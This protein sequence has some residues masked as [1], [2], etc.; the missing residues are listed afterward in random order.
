[1]VAQGVGSGHET[2]V[3]GFGGILQNG[4]VLQQANAA[5][6]IRLLG[7]SERLVWYHPGA[8]DVAD[9][10]VD[11]PRGLVLPGWFQP[12]VT[13][14]AFGVVLLALVRGRRLGRVVTE[15]LPVVVRASETTEGRGR[16][17]RR[18]NDRARAVEILRAG[19]VRRLSK[20]L[21]LQRARVDDDVL[22]DAIGRATGLD[23]QR[24][25]AVLLDPVED[26]DAALIR[27]AQQLT[28][29]EDKVTHP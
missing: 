4:S 9:A 2:W 7:G 19:T 22:V 16:L 28:E 1:V 27:C 17:Y 5:A 14:L 15:P 29:L 23:P 6:A 24:I 25:R 13:L 8:A 3:L 20:R 18:A 26:D 11:R 21:G 10:A 12:L